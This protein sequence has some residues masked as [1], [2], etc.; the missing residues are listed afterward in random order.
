MFAACL[1]DK[2]ELG[3]LKVLFAIKEATILL[4]FWQIVLSQFENN[5]VHGREK[6]LVQWWPQMLTQDILVS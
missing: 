6:I 3:C 4:F 1:Q 2:N 5:Q